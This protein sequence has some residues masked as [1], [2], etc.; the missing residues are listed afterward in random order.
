MT[1]DRPV[2][3]TA[4]HDLVRGLEAELVDMSV[5]TITAWDLATRLHRKLV[6]LD[7]IAASRFAS[8]YLQSDGSIHMTPSGQ[9]PQLALPLTALPSP[10]PR[11]KR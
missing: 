9:T 7:A 10:K 11:R 2:T 3:K 6:E 1:R 8:N 4:A 5:Q